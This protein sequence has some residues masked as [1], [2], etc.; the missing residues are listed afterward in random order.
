MKKALAQAQITFGKK[1]A[2]GMCLVL[3]LVLGVSCRLSCV[4]AFFSS[5]RWVCVFAQAHDCCGG[6]GFV[7]IVRVVE[8]RAVLSWLSV[9]AH[10]NTSPDR[11]LVSVEDIV[12]VTNAR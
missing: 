7:L 2:C 10:H 3:V 1:M 9:L 11:A 4:H 6:L 8:H 5:S 12:Q